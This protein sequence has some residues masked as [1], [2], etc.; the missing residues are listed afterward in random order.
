[1]VQLHIEIKAQKG[2]NPTPNM[3]FRKYLNNKNDFLKRK[4]KDNFKFLNK[5]KK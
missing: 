5:L 1:M 4:F 3:L 2:M